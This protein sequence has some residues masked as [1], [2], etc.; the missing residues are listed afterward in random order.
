M[1]QERAVTGE[2]TNAVDTKEQNS[3]SHQTA[4]EIC[5]QSTATEESTNT[6]DAQVCE[7]P[8]SSSALA[9]EGGN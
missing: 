4:E 7:E 2:S 6:V 5:R 9:A 1:C 3:G 8:N